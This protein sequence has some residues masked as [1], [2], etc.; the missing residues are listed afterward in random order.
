MNDIENTNKKLAESKFN[1]TPSKTNKSRKK[2]GKGHKTNKSSELLDM[3]I[4]DEA[5]A[6]AE[7]EALDLKVEEP[8]EYPSVEDGSKFLQVNVRFLDSEQELRQ[9]FG[10]AVDGEG[11]VARREGVRRGHGHL[12]HVREKRK[13]ILQQPKEEWPVYKSTGLSMD[14]LGKAENGEQVFKF[15]HSKT[16]MAIQEQFYLAVRSYNPENFT[17]LIRMA[18]FHVDTN[19]QLSEIIRH[20]GDLSQ[21]AELVERALYTFDTA[22]HPLFNI[23]TGKQR[24]PYIYGENRSFFHTVWR[25]IQNLGRRGCWRACFEF[26]K[27]LFAIEPDEDPLCSLLFLDMTA[28]KARRYDYLVAFKQKWPD[29]AQLDPLPNIAF[30]SALAQWHLDRENKKLLTESTKMMKD[31]IARFPWMVNRILMEANTNPVDCFIDFKPETLLQNV[32]TE[33]YILHSKDLWQSPEILTFLKSCATDP[34]K[35]VSTVLSDTDSVPDNVARHVLLLEERKVLS[36]LPSEITSKERLSTDPLPPQDSISPY[37]SL[38]DAPQQ[39][40]A[41]RG[42]IE[43]IRQTFRDDPQLQEELELAEALEQDVRDRSN[44]EEI[45]SNEGQPAGYTSR[46]QNAL[47]SIYEYMTGPGTNDNDENNDENVSQEDEVE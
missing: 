30:S 24:L 19:L 43:F 32:Y 16:Y 8:E 1:A 28:L 6:Q 44:Q 5:I 27:L 42:L 31:A 40:T 36:L 4:L 26:S 17:T 7:K 25:H 23:A 37:A 11:R 22:L 20:Q 34:P 38:L 45:Q 46:L 33:L 3:H 35:D 39:Q 15:T 29:Q 10:K 2:K 14:F 41:S 12:S 18:P 21:S 13:A 47:R 9:V